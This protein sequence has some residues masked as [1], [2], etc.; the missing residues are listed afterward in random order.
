MKLRGLVWLRGKLQFRTHLAQTYPPLLG[1]KFASLVRDSLRFHQFNNKFHDVP[2]LAQA[3]SYQ[4]PAAMLQAE[5]DIVANCS[6]GN[7]TD[8]QKV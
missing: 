4:L 5:A 6:R 7:E 2:E 8:P 1:L 3:T